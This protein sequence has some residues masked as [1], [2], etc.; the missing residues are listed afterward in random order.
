MGQDL[1]QNDEFNCLL[2]YNVVS[3]INNNS[4]YKHTNNITLASKTLINLGEELKN[5]IKETENEFNAR[6]QSNNKK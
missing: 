5:I 3:W 6:K 2:G 1:E 4:M